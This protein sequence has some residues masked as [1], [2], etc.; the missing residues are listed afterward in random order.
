MNYDAII[1]GAGHNGLVTGIYLARAV[2]KA[3]ILE[4]NTEAGGAIR[5]AEVTLPGFKHDLFATNLTLFASS[6]FYQEFKGQLDAQGLTFVPSALP[7]SSVYPDG[8]YLGVSTDLQATLN[9]FRSISSHDA[10]IW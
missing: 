6:P 9:N 7:F 3:L 1:V 4:R 5:T 2:W 8:T 10:D